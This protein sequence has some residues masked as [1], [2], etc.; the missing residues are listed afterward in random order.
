MISLL[1]GRKN[2]FEFRINSKLLF[3]K[4]QVLVFYSQIYVIIIT[5]SDDYGRLLETISA[6]NRRF[7]RMVIRRQKNSQDV[8]TGSTWVFAL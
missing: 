1:K 4:N 3:R 7:L 5:G 2:F 8:E 6:S